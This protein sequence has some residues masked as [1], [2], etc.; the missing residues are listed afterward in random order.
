MLFNST[1]FAIFFPIVLAVYWLFWKWRQAQNIV[2]VAASGYFY[3]QF[4]HTFPIY[5][6]AIITTGYFFARLIAPEEDQVKRKRLL[7]AGICIISLGLVY[8]KYSGLLLGSFPGLDEWQASAMHIVIPIGISYFTF[9]SIGYI[10]DVYRRKTAVEKN[11]ITYAAY[12]SYFPHILCGPI[13]SSATILP[14][15]SKKLQLNLQIIEL[16]CSEILWGLFRKIVVADNIILVVN[17]CFAHYNDLHGSTLLLGLCLFSF[18]IYADF[19]GYSDIAR[20]VSR[21]MGIELI[22]NFQLPLFARNPGELWRRWHTSLRKWILDYIYLPMGGNKG[23]KAHYILLMFFIFGFSGLWHGASIAFV[24]WGLLNGVYFLIYILTDNLTHYK[25]AP[26]QGKIFPSLKEASQILF[27]FALA[28]I[29]RIFFRSPN[30]TV[31]KEFFFKIFST[32]LFTMPVTMVLE[33]FKWVAPMIIIE[34]LQRE[35]SYIL[36]MHKF[37]FAIRLVVY[38]AIITSI[39]LLAKTQNTTEC[40]Y[41]K[42]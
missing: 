35:K 33:Q 5:L 41:F 37:H 10:T 26:A 30:M 16:S 31:A 15:F 25:G 2:L 36:E 20:G 29:M 11:Y 3:Y 34:W 9:S 28:T 7:I 6:T 17:Y 14:Q 32:D 4:H 40:Y 24:F 12:I 42:F 38:A 1:G 39:C 27:T 22:R 18:Y 19:S 23:S 8:I 13:P 21:L